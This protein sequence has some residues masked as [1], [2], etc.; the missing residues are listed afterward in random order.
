MGRGLSE[1]DSGSHPAGSHLPHSYTQRARNSATA[2]TMVGWTVKH[3]ERHRNTPL[4]RTDIA[5]Q[6][7]W[8]TV[9]AQS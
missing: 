7:E 3:R 9:E 4:S 6:S 1:C 2:P 5:P 8:T